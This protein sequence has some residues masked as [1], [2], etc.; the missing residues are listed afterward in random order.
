MC[1]KPSAPATSG[2]G[3]ALGGTAG[4]AGYPHD[5]DDQC[6]LLRRADAFMYRG[7]AT[8]ACAPELNRQPT[9][10]GAAAAAGY[11]SSAE[12]GPSS[13]SGGGTVA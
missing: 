1:R 3:P 10:D 8:Q 12:P 5:G 9:S 4:I 6:A 11:P 7:K 13:E 2:H